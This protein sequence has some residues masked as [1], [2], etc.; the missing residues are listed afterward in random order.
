I[1]LGIGSTGF[2]GP[3]G[4]VSTTAPRGTLE[5]H[6]VSD[7]PW[8]VE[9]PAPSATYATFGEA[10]KDLERRIRRPLGTFAD[11]ASW[12]DI[13]TTFLYRDQVRLRRSIKGDAYWTVEDRDAPVR[14]RARRMELVTVSAKAPGVGRLG[15][16]LGQA[17]WAEDFVYSADG[18]DGTVFAYVCR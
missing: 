17:G 7:T 6:A 16:A 1:T 4:V 13:D 14:V 11:S 2:A 12:R 10:R 9:R 8:T 3:A 18:P 15:D 5:T